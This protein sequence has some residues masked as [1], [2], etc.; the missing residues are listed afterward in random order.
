[1]NRVFLIDDKYEKFC[2]PCSV[3][4][5]E[6]PLTVLSQLFCCEPFALFRSTFLYNCGLVVIPPRRTCGHAFFKILL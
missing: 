6:N 3:F 2:C 5:R 1:M 4:E